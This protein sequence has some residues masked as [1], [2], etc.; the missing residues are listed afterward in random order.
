MSLNKFLGVALLGALGFVLT[1]PRGMAGGPGDFST[2]GE[3]V[4]TLPSTSVG[5]GRW[6]LRPALYV[7]GSWADLNQVLLGSAGEQ[8]FALERAGAGRLRAVFYGQPTLTLD[9][10]ALEVLD[11]S[12]GVVVGPVFASGL[13]VVEEAGS[14]S[15]PSLLPAAGPLP[16]GLAELSQ[17]GILD[18]GPV[19]LHLLSPS[20]R[21]AEV[22]AKSAGFAVEL[23]LLQR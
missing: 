12:T 14:F 7:E 19:D 11:V 8:G 16:L 4:G 10:H 22:T 9:R 18:A 1:G 3:E 13:A 2:G 21:H 5:P 17:A 23:D 6:V 20:H 15:R